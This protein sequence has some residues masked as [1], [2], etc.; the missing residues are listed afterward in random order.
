[1]SYLIQH[2]KVHN[3]KDRW[4]VSAYILA[5]RKDYDVGLGV[6]SESEEEV[7]L[8][9]VTYY[10]YGLLRQINYYKGYYAS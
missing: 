6:L 8:F 5:H 2:Y 9:L 7:I 1:M 4:H 10:S 3:L